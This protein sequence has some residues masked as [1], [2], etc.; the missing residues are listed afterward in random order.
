MIVYHMF[1]RDPEPVSSGNEHWRDVGRRSPWRAV[2]EVI[3]L[4]NGRCVV[5]WPTSV[6]VYD[7][8]ESA[9]AVHIGHMGGR[10]SETEFRVVWSDIPDFM[11]G[12]ENA[13]QDS[14]EGAPWGVVGGRGVE[15][16]SV[17]PRAPEWDTLTSPAGFLRGYIAEGRRVFGE[18]RS[19]E[20]KQA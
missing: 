14:M 10:G 13:S 2:A 20:E 19:P 9:R 11:R 4:G 6:I 8:E 12:V 16:G 3:V 18:I 7:D 15:D 5:A 17:T 1:R